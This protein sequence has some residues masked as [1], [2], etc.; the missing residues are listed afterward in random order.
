[1]KIKIKNK[2]ESKFDNAIKSI[3]LNKVE[4]SYK[5]SLKRPNIKND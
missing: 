3:K 5:N 4:N 2:K 1:M